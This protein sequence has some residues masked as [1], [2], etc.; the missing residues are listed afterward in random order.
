MLNLLHRIDQPA[1]L[2]HRE[3][4]HA[5]ARGLVQQ[6]VGHVGLDALLSLTLHPAGERLAPADLLQCRAALDVEAVEDLLDLVAVLDGQV[7]LQYAVEVLLRGLH[8]HLCIGCSAGG[9]DVHQ[10][11]AFVHGEL[12]QLAEALRCQL[13]VASGRGEVLP[14]PHVADALAGDRALGELTRSAAHDVDLALAP[15]GGLGGGSQ[16]CRDDTGPHFVGNRALGGAH[17][18]LRASDV[19]M[20]FEHALI[21]QGA[22]G[23][24]GLSGHHQGLHELVPRSEAEHVGHYVGMHA[25]RVVGHPHAAQR[26]IGFWVD[27]LRQRRA[28]LAAAERR[29]DVLGCGGARL[30]RALATA[31]QELVSAEHRLCQHLA[32][33][34]LLDLGAQRIGLALSRAEGLVLRLGQ[35][36]HVADH[37][38]RKL[39][40]RRVRC[41]TPKR[42][43]RRE[44]RRGHPRLHGAGVERTQVA[45]ALSGLDRGVGCQHPVEHGAHVRCEVRFQVRQVL[46]DRHE[47]TAEA[48][49]GRLQLDARCPP[50]HEIG[51]DGPREPFVLAALLIERR[52]QPV[53]ERIEGRRARHAHPREQSAHVLCVDT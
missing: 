21:G 37:P 22:D 46:V 40:L 32:P 31:S 6:V 45:R 28:Q 34:L 5:D 36:A 3:V 11:V 24:L 30:D 17:Q 52:S 50:L 19:A 23:V 42:L 43:I 8:F 47:P 13:G 29:I 14:G 20:D 53:G 12:V 44:L 2:F 1:E 33:H 15:V 49:E 18:G 39:S 48:I 51:F 16:L 4:F 38:G 35:V 25:D 9:M 41:F 10:L 26:S 7:G 27:L